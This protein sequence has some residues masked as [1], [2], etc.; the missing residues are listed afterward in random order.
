MIINIP[1]LCAILGVMILILSLVFSW[2][3]K[4]ERR[5]ARIESKL[6]NFCKKA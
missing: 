4:I 5:L 1:E 3:F 6:D 2:A